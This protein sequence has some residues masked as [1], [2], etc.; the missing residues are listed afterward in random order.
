VN[1]LEG[2]AARAAPG[3]GG[4]VAVFISARGAPALALA[5]AAPPPG[6]LAY[7]PGFPRGRPGELA[8]H[9]IGVRA[10]RTSGRHGAAAPVLVWAEMGR[11]E[12]LPEPL[13]GLAGAPLLDGS[14]R[15]VG[16]VLGAAPRRGR[17]YAAPP[18]E[19]AAALAAAHVAH[20]AQ[21]GGAAISPVNYGLA[22][23]ALRRA[24]R[25][26]PTA[27]ISA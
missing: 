20:P 13:T 17:L 16:L 22:A 7:A 21:A 11:T 2:V 12:G 26:A 18:A 4:R 9:L 14:G 25:V 5:A 3:P 1:D 10:P 15:V 8:A 23:D 27:C 24:L 6:E 19:L